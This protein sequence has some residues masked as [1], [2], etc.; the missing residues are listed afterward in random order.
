MGEERGVYRVL[1]GIDVR[2]I[3]RWIFSKWNVGVWIG[4]AKDRDGWQ[5]LV[6]VVMN[7]RVPYNVGN[8]LTGYKPVSFS[9][10]TLLHG[11]SK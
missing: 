10:R 6:D 11:V 7:L 9:R 5:A 4:L 1:M 3:L 2:I 8:S